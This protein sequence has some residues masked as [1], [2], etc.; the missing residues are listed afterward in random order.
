[1]I[2]IMSTHY[3]SKQIGFA[4]T[5]WVL[6]L[7]LMAG[8]QPA[9]ADLADLTRE[10]EVVKKA[11]DKAFAD[12]D[13]G[14]L[15]PLR[16]SLKAA[17][18]TWS[19]FYV[20]YRGWGAGTDP[21]WMTD[22]DAIQAEFMNATNALTPGNN[23][24]LAAASLQRIRDLMGGLLERNDVPDVDAAVQKLNAS[25]ADVQTSIKSLQGKA[26]GTETLATLTEQWTNIS[27]SWISLNEALI[28]SNRLNLS[29]RELAN[30]KQKV[31]RQSALFETV[32]GALSNANLTSGLT[33]LS[34]AMEGLCALASQWAAQ[35]GSADTAG[36]QKPLDPKPKRRLNFR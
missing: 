15:R 30:L 12:A 21:T 27:E 18:E 25:L 4:A 36:D 32:S 23:A 16:S 33:S 7:V 2:A 13:A 10:V 9:A 34:S 14:R 28:N 31:Q 11:I 6:A 5:A 22:I 19:R 24:P 17:Q 3:F 29:D 35:S 20:G 1:V 8:S 26:V